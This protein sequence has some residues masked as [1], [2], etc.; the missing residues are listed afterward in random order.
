MNGKKEA[1]YFGEGKENVT[2]P[3]VVVCA[4]AISVCLHS[5][6]GMGSDYLLKLPRGWGRV[7]I[8][9]RWGGVRCVNLGF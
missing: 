5:V 4:A 3:A 2:E 8:A 6:N 1:W 9:Y 7:C